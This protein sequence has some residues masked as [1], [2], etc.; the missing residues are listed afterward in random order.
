MSAVWRCIAA[1][2]WARAAPNIA[3]APESHK[4][5]AGFFFVQGFMS[6]DLDRVIAMQSSTL[7]RRRDAAKA[8]RPIST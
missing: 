8:R 3:L 4:L 2:P 1:V 7:S 5:S 6:V